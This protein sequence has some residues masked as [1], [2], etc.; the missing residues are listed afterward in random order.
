MKIRLI[1]ALGAV[2]A[3]LCVPGG[4]VASAPG[5]TLTPSSLTF[6]SPNPEGPYPSQGFTITNSG[7]APLVI[8]NITVEAPAA[9]GGS[10]FT[11][12]N[13]CYPFPR[14]LA[15]NESCTVTV[16]FFP[17]GYGMR[18]GAI[19]IADDAAGSPHLV[20]LTG[21][22]YP[23]K[24]MYTLDGYGGLHPD[25]PVTP[26]MT[27]GAYWAGWKIARAAALLSDASGGYTLDG[28]GGLHPF[29]SALP[30][31]GAAYF[32][33]DVARD[34]VLLPGSTATYAP[35]YV[36]DGW[37]ALHPFGGA[38]PTTETPYWKGWDIAKKVNLLPDGSGGYVMDG[39]GGLHPFGVGTNTP[40]RTITDAAY[41][42]NWSIARDFALF[43][44]S[45]ASAPA[46]VTLDGYGGVHAFGFTAPP[47]QLGGS[48]WPGWNIAR[49]VRV[50]PTSTPSNPGGWVME[51]LGGVHPYGPAQSIPQG[52]Y[53]NW[54]IAVELVVVR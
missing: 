42:R 53:W 9:G 7:D 21:H 11:Q 38:L 51:G 39:W 10:E 25:N 50:N 8:S 3:A 13:N 22:A 31:V 23:F 28:Y 24:A 30:A 16:G 40:P 15:P 35:G 41:W 20:A 29:G 46:G 44:N 6:G 43:S 33:W 36:L 1:V 52:P 49:S 47:A 17:N 5:V 27:G 34:V 14:A 18:T 12:T 54:D 19:A 32:G 2:L 4:A 45:T 26:V 48:Y 37:G